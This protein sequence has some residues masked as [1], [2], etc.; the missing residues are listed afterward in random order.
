MYQLALTL[1]WDASVQYQETSV[2]NLGGL[3]RPTWETSMRSSTHATVGRG[4]VTHVT[5]QAFFSSLNLFPSRFSDPLQ[6]KTL[7]LLLSPQQ[8]LDLLYV[9]PIIGIMGCLTP[10]PHAPPNPL[11]PLP[12]PSQDAAHYSCDSLN[13]SRRFG[14]WCTRCLP[15]R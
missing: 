2:Y 7:R 5:P 15:C 6:V 3:V 11:A 9:K 4:P 12:Q 8:R 1:S 13:T 10:P 14:L